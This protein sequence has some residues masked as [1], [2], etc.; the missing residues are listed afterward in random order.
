LRGVLL[1]EP[2]K[3]DLF[4]IDLVHTSERGSLL[5]DPIILDPAKKSV[6][7]YS[8]S[9]LGKYTFRR[10]SQSDDCRAAPSHLLTLISLAVEP[11]PGFLTD[12]FCFQPIGLSETPLYI[13]KL[14]EAAESAL[15]VQLPGDARGEVEGGRAIVKAIFNDMFILDKDTD[16]RI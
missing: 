14:F 3:L 15:S 4:S 16:V 11:N 8:F 5:E 1:E 12:P 13:E 7:L 2:G 9:C 6:V 10:Q